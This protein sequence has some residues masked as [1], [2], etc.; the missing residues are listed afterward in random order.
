MPKYKLTQ[1]TNFPPSYHQVLGSQVYAYAYTH[2]HT[3]ACVYTHT[4][5][6]ARACV[7]TTHPTPTETKRKEAIQSSD[8]LQESN[9]GVRH[10]IFLYIN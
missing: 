10:N 3:Y 2:T 7:H 4:H 8:Y 9:K 1:R 6:H 5:T